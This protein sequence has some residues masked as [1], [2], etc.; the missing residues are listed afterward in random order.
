MKV[1]IKGSERICNITLYHPENGECIEW[2]VNELLEN[3]DGLCEKLADEDKA[4]FDADC[5]MTKRTYA[6]LYDVVGQMQKRYDKLNMVSEPYRSYIT[7][8]SQK[9]GNFY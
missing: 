9:F 2:F 3:T 6:R 8:N 4:Y 1:Y 5:L 7:S